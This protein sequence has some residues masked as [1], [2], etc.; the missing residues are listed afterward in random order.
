MARK[1]HCKCGKY[2]GEI[3]DATLAKGLTFNC[4]KCS[5][6]KN[7]FESEL[8]SIRKKQDYLDAFGS[9]GNRYFKG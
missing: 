2:V 6:P 8:D 9:F 4:A 5:E 3:R 1:I 7:I